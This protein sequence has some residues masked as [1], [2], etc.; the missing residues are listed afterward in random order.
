MFSLDPAST[1]TPILLADILPNFLIRRC[2]ESLWFGYELV[3]LKKLHRFKHTG[4]F[5][6]S[7]MSAFEAITI[8]WQQAVLKKLEEQQGNWDSNKHLAGFIRVHPQHS[9][10]VNSNMAFTSARLLRLC[11][12]LPYLAVSSHTHNQ[13]YT[14]SAIEAMC[15]DTKTGRMKDGC[16]LNHDY[17][18]LKSTSPKLRVIARIL[19]DHEGANVLTMSS[20]TEMTLVT[21]RVS[22]SPLRDFQ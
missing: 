7:Y 18:I 4:Q 21:E 16:V 3:E 10:A 17:A 1:T 14:N 6:V 22:L 19:K 15:M 20:F 12:C 8:N 13:K 5:P 2:E 9:T 11:S